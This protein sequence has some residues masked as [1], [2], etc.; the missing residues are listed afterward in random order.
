VI[1]AVLGGSF[2]PVHTGHIAMVDHILVNGL[3]DL[4]M[5]VPAW[6]SPH[7]TAQAASPT[8]R[9]AMVK[10]AFSHRDSVEIDDREIAGGRVAYTVDTL[11]EMRSQYAD[12][13]LRLVIGADQL[14][15]FDAWYRP[16]RILELVELVVLARPG[17]QLDASGLVGQGWPT[18]R[19]HLCPDFHEPV[20][21]SEIRAMIGRGELP[22]EFLPPPVLE[23]IRR[24]DLYGV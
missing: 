12:D 19:I 10:L 21:S 9:L 3:A 16:G 7:K 13:E 15:V 8:D 22:A 23:Y 6:R 18:D 5:L 2:D 1:R 14:A 4:V 17:H 11:A 20:A 24:E